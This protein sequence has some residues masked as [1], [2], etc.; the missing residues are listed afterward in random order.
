MYYNTEKKCLLKKN[1][2]KKKNNLVKKL[3]LKI[4]GAMKNNGVKTYKFFVISLRFDLEVKGHMAQDQR[5]RESRSNE[6]SKQR[7][8]GSRQHQ[9]ASFLSFFR[10]D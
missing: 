6:G 8:M 3:F 9:V 4:I 10:L 1:G 5:S 2:V 7:Q